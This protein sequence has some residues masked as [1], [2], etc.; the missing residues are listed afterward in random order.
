MVL[1]M[2]NGIIV[3]RTGFSRIGVEIIINDQTMGLDQ[4]LG[5]NKT[6]GFNKDMDLNK[7][8]GPNKDMGLKITVVN[9]I[10]LVKTMVLSKETNVVTT[11]DSAGWK[12][13]DHWRSTCPS[14]DS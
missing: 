13:L 3:V 5:F 2:F 11:A 8:K 12:V 10:D 6:M 4:I 1:T 7:I 9:N 14:E